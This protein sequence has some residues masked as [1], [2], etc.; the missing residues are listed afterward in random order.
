M[1]EADTQRGLVIFS[2]L[3]NFVDW[4]D[5]ESEGKILGRSEKDRCQLVLR[6]LAAHQEGQNYVMQ[7]EQ[8]AARLWGGPVGRTELEK[9]DEAFKSKP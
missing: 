5:L 7:P 3:I 8:I 2:A 4:L 9:K 1:A 6:F